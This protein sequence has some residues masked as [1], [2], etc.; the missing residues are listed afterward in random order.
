M[1]NPNSFSENVI[2]YILQK[3]GHFAQYWGEVAACGVK[4]P[5]PS[6]S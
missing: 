4:W 1:S 6:K 5:T 2:L 3:G